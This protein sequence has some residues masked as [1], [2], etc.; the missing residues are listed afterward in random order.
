MEKDMPLMGSLISRLSMARKESVNWKKCQQELLK[1]KCKEKK[2][3]KKSGTSK[4]YG[5]FSK[6][7]TGILEERENWNRRN[8]LSNNDPEFSKINEIHQSTD[9]EAQRTPNRIKI[10]KST[11]RHV[12][13]NCRKAKTKRKSSKKTEEKPYG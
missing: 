3:F 12:I 13:S 2:E 10:L 11:P 4:N 6:G 9:W 7:V 5:N 1:S 8:S